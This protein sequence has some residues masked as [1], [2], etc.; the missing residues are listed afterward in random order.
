MLE[1]LLVDFDHVFV[2]YF[3]SAGFIFN[4]DKCEVKVPNI[5]LLKVNNGNIRTT[6]EIYSKLTVKAP[7]RSRCSGVFIVNFEHI[8]TF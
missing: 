3:L 8:L 5:Y 7:E 6:C 2:W 1:A 4:A